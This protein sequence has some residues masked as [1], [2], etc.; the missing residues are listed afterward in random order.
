MINSDL[1]RVNRE[2]LRIL[3][4]VCIFF[5][6]AIT[7][8]L[9]GASGKEEKLKKQVK[10]LQYQHDTLRNTVRADIADREGNQPYLQ[11]VSHMK[12]LGL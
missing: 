1:K 7:V 9:I 10:V 12:S 8:M 3:A 6:S 2:D 5:L 4:G 11:V